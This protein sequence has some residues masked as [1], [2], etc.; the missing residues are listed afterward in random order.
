MA[1]RLGCELPD[2]FAAIAPISGQPLLG[3]NCAPSTGGSL[4]ILSVWATQDVVVPGLDITNY[5][6]LYYTPI[7][8]VMY[9][10]GEH[11][12]CNV[13]E[14]AY[15]S[16]STTADGVRGWQCVGYD[17]CDFDVMSCSWNATH[18][19]YPTTYTED[20]HFGLDVVWN[21]FQKY[22]KPQLKRRR[23]RGG[24]GGRGKGRMSALMAPAMQMP[25][26]ATSVSDSG[27]VYKIVVR[28]EQFLVAAAAFVLLLCTVG[29]GIY[30][31]KVRG[32]DQD[33]KLY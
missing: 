3:F 7:H 24:K 13:E 16:V 14:E 17:S 6:G 8:Q 30:A 31:R 32:R 4:P 33:N 12:G 26:P 10:M 23:R 28:P 5:I 29:C 21:F 11:N 18:N 27:N 15:V 19:D 22:S 9:V 20:G 25:L 2:R 1:H